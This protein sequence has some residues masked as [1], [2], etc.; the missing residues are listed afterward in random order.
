MSNEPTKREP[1]GAAVRKYDRD[2]LLSAFILYVWETPLPIVAE[3]CWKNNVTTHTIYEWDEFKF[4]VQLCR[5]KKQAV[6]EQGALMGTLNC[7]M[8]IFSLR[9][10]GGGN[11]WSETTKHEVTGK[12]GGPV[13]SVAVTADMTADEATNAYLR[14]ISG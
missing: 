5:D 12:D 1:A 10:L 7:Q 13:A 14:L 3:F 6:L 8:A 4:A 2:A 9:N 11:S